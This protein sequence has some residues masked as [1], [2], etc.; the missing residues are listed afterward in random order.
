GPLHSNYRRLA[1][2]PSPAEVI[3]ISDGRGA[4]PW[5]SGGGN[6]C[7]DIA[8]VDGQVDAGRHAGCSTAQDRMEKGALNCIFVDGHVKF[9]PLTQTISPKNLWSARDTD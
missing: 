6:G 5:V 9:I 3:I 2:I 1:S 4:S 7:T 8:S